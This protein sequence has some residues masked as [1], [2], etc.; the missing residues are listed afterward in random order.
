M[1]HY[2]AGT[3]TR[4]IVQDP[5][6][7]VRVIDHLGAKLHTLIME[8]RKDL[9]VVSGMAEGFDE[10]L[11]QAAIETNVPFIAA[12]PNPGYA[13]YYWHRNSQTG[14]DRIDD[15]DEILEMAW[16]VAYVSEGIYTTRYGSKMHS[17]FARNI[18]MVDLCNLLWSFD[19][20]DVD[21]GTAHA[22][23]YAMKTSK[24]IE[25]IKVE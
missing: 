16:K 4:K 25:Y 20:G 18:Y 2:I 12:I 3:G 11:A 14:R 19:N 8:G 7:M 5:D 15:F 21:G 24:L 6:R 10:A 9:V 23:K 17:N 22:T 13:N 1:T